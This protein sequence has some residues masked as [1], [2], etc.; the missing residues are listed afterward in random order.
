MIRMHWLWMVCL[1]AG[2]GCSPSDGKIE[3]VGTVMCDGK[4]LEAAA[5]AFVGAGGGTYAT[6]STD[7][8]GKFTVR[9]EPGQNKVSVS[10]MDTSKAA[11]WANIPE[12]QRLAGTPEQMAE[13]MKN[14]PKPLVAQKFFNPD[15]SG[16]SIDIKDGMAEVKIEVT[17]KN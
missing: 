12:E 15:T 14:A 8:N 3:V 17:A 13:A 5:I 10:K 11:E 7:A 9:A 4:P 6:A 2:L 16:I 1:L